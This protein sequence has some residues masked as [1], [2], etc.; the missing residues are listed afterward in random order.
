MA[1]PKAS[2]AFAFVLRQMW[3]LQQAQDACR[4][5]QRPMISEL[6]HSRILLIGVRNRAKRF[7]G[8][9]RYHAK[10]AIDPRGSHVVF[11]T[12]SLEGNLEPERR[13]VPQLA[14]NPVVRAVRFEYLA[15][16]G[17]P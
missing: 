1:I 16:D 6:S 7:L 4:R 3:R 9:T 12:D 10:P 17:E 15:R 5:L 13:S 14:L 2:S 8:A 11:M